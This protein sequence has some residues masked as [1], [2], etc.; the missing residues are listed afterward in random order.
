MGTA[1]CGDRVAEG[2][3]ATAAPTERGE[4]DERRHS[5]DLCG[6]EADEAREGTRRRVRRDV[7]R[8][9]FFMSCRRIARQLHMMSKSSA[10]SSMATSLALQPP[11]AAFT[12]EDCAPAAS[13]SRPSS[14][15]P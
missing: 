3:V 1:R 6:A 8:G 15:H 14:T 10:E 11:A 2:G 7:R 4:D 13:M 9:H 5:K 12:E